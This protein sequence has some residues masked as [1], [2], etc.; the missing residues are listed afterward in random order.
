[1]VHD[2]QNNEHVE[3]S[4]STKVASL[5]RARMMIKLENTTKDLKNSIKTPQVRVDEAIK[6]DEKFSTLSSSLG[7]LCVLL[8]F[9][10]VGWSQLRV[11][12]VLRHRSKFIVHVKNHCC[13]CGDKSVLISLGH[14][15]SVTN[16]SS[17]VYWSRSR[18]LD[19]LKA[20][21]KARTSA[22]HTSA[23]TTKKRN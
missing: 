14:L 18:Q 1:M 6:L 16:L 9:N 12:L 11:R 20:T 13:C 8:S 23:I 21:Q 4:Y 22:W 17:N 15:G 7:T 3:I 19:D 10:C 5:S 2:R